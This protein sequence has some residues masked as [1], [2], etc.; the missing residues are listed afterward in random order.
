VH[1][2]GK[3][4]PNDRS[5]KKLKKGNRLV[6][7]TIQ[8]GGEDG[9]GKV[10]VRYKKKKTGERRQKARKTNMQSPTFGE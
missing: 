2:G 6:M 9:F 4:K 7:L 8:R 1:I 10:W 3:T 5:M